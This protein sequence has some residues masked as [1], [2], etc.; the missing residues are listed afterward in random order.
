LCFLAG[1]PVG[2][3]VALGF[4]EA[5][6][7]GG[8]F[9]GV[10]VWPGVGAADGV[11][12]ATVEVFG[13]GPPLGAAADRPRTISPPTTSATTTATA[14]TPTATIRRRRDATF[15]GIGTP[16]PRTPT[17]KDRPDGGRRYRCLLLSGPPIANPKPGGC[18]GIDI[19][20]RR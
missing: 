11:R 16:F 15:A 3:G 14:T 2:L 4:D 13:V 9:E 7:E 19:V 8:R 10:E 5:F 6:P 18:T 1:P 12:A 20:T 17:T